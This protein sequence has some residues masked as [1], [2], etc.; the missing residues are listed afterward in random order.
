MLMEVTGYELHELKDNFTGDIV[1]NAVWFTCPVCNEASLARFHGDVIFNK[2]LH[3]RCC[4]ISFSVK[5]SENLK[6]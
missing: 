2:P 6:V 4:K 1:D 5:V 3:A